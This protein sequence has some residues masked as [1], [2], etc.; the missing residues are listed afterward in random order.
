MKKVF[1]LA[2]TLMVSAGTLEAQD[3]LT[4]D[5]SL[6]TTRIGTRGATFLQVGVGAR[7]Q[8]L[9]GAYTALANDIS[10]LYWNTAGIGQIENFAAGMSQAYLYEDLDITH[11]FIGAVLPVG[12]TR[13][14][15]SVN[16][17]QSGEMAW[18]SENFPNAG[19]GGRTDPIRTN[20]EWKGTAVG[21]HLAR[22]ITDRLTV[23]VAGKFITEGINNAEA[24]Y[25]GVDMGTVFRTGLYGITIGASLANLGSEGRFEGNLL[26]QQVNTGNSESQ[27]LGDF[28]RQV[29]VADYT[30]DMDLPT[31]FR[32]SVM[33]DLV[34]DATAMIAPNPDQSLRLL[35]DLNDAIDTDM[36]T[37]VGMEYGFREMAF[38]RVGKK[39]FNEAQ[40]D[41]DFTEGASFGG[42]LNLPVGALGN[43]RLD[44]AYTDM[45]DLENVQMFNVEIHF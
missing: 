27:G 34:G 43:L 29:E 41:R 4:S 17:L 5:P 20:F 24:T 16:I 37:S 2:L 42:G 45:G 21:L 28:V 13:I 36:Q 44:Y 30:E 7:A 1:I 31:T 9:G 33:A 35:W 38:L 3:F 6:P 39:W 14:G 8:A 12:L 25:V 11:S 26:R 22:P 18:Q 19:F 23:G 40:I 15:L 10:A 32:F